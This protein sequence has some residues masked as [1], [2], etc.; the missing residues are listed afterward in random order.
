MVALFHSADTIFILAFAI[1]MLN[2]DLHSP[3]IKPSLKM[4]VG[5]FINNLRGIDAGYDIDRFILH[6]FFLNMSYTNFELLCEISNKYARQIRHR[7]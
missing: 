4:K 7:F 5:D 1:V 3:N 2:T 6:K